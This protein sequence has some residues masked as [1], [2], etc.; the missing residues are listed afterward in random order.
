MQLRRGLIGFIVIIQSILFLTHFLLYETWSF[1]SSP[2]GSPGR[3]SVKLALSL[4]SVSFVG[5]SLLAFRFT[6]SA[7]RAFYKVA[8]VWTGLVSFLFF[9]ALSAWI[10]FGV[11]TVAG[12]SVDFHKMVEWL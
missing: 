7:V 11:A 4:L 9:A 1:S 6:N 3:L 2:S 10:I 12:L 5:A 8:A